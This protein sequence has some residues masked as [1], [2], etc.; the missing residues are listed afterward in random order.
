MT[1]DS[2]QFLRRVVQSGIVPV[3]DLESWLG[4]RPELLTLPPQDLAR[5]LVRTGWL[6]R[7]QA[8]QVL[9]GRQNSLILG[10]YEI[11]APIARGGMALVLLAQAR[12]SRQLVTLKLLPRSQA[13]TGKCA[14]L[15]HEAA[16]LQSLQMDGI[17]RFLEAGSARG[18]S[19]L[20]MEYIRGQNLHRIV[21]DRGPLA[22]PE[23]CRIFAHVARI[24]AHLHGQGIVHRD[25]K[26]A[27]IL[28]EV[29]GKVYVI[30]FGLALYKGREPLEGNARRIVG[31]WDYV[32]PEQTYDSRHVTAAADAYSLGAS[33]FFALTGQAP[34][35]VADR[36]Q[37]IELHRHWQ[38]PSPGVFLTSLPVQLNRLIEMLM[39][40]DPQSRLQDLSSVARELQRLS[41][42][43]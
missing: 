3:A 40:K 14:R 13:S 19:Y 38:P 28:C 35:A 42:A 8:Q 6:T 18:A 15:Q 20:A 1:G 9:A 37:K 22:W 25:L 10:G 41:Q 43:S 16:I 29:S 24:M 21:R 33:L 7:F 11:L 2:R 5:E 30:D 17:P 27:N 4:T 31:T 39:A 34:F 32:A 26:P 36:L 12:Q 23:A